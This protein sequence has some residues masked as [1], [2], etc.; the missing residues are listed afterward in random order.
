MA[1][2]PRVV[3]ADAW[4][5]LV[6]AEG[7]PVDVLAAV[8][9]LTALHAADLEAG[10][11]V[12]RTATATLGRWR[13]NRAGRWDQFAAA[14][15][16]CC[17]AATQARDAASPE[18]LVAGTIGPVREPFEPMAVPPGAVVE[19]EVVEQA[20]LLAP[21]V[22]LLI[23]LDMSTGAEASAAVTAAASTGRPVWV[24]LAVSPD[25]PTALVGGE[26]VAEAARLVAAAGPDAI[27]V[28]APTPELAA[29]ALAALMACE[30]APTMLR[31]VLAGAPA[32]HSPAAFAQFAREWMRAGVDILAADRGATSQHVAALSDLIE[33]EWR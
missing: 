11:A 30:L 29:D 32:E 16:A 8:D 33:T 24:G 28:N 12:V 2:P 27:L 21:H 17:R 3:D 26:P 25:R 1:G 18:A 15:T 22:D 6:P 4:S 9:D 23:C 13:M 7:E 10:A 14:N 5:R 31:G 20:L 19:T